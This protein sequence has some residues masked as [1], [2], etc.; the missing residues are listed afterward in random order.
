MKLKTQTN[1]SKSPGRHMNR[2]AIKTAT[3]PGGARVQSPYKQLMGCSGGRCMVLVS[4]FQPGF[5]ENQA[6]GRFKP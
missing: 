6:G 3:P 4:K 1:S 5:R 2:P